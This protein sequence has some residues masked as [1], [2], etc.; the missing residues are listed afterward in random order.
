M[1]PITGNAARK[2]KQTLDNL[3]KEWEDQ[4]GSDDYVPKTGTKEDYDMLVA[5]VEEATRR[6]ESISALTSR[7][8]ELGQSVVSLAKT[9]NII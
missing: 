1:S 9:L 4:G 2:A 5:A 6:N 3:K 7:L 8:E